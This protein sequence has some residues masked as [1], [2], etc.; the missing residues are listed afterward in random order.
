MHL[1]MEIFHFVKVVQKLKMAS[2]EKW[3]GMNICE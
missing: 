1:I 3:E 2:V